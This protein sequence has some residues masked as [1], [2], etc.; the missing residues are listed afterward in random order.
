[1]KI[2]HT[3]DWHLGRSLHSHRRYEEFEAFLDWLISTIE[4]EKV[5]ALL[6]AGDIFDTGTPSNRAQSL[7]YK[8]L[9]KVSSTHCRHIVITA[10]NHDSPTFLNASK[11]LLKELNVH[12]VGAIT[13]NLE[14]EVIV[15]KSNNEPQAIICAVPYLRDKDIRTAEPGETIEDKNAK[16]IEGISNHYAEVYQIAQQKRVELNKPN[17]PIIAMGHLFTAGGK[18][19]DG[20]GV[21]ELYI[22]SLTHVH[23]EKLPQSI[24][25]FALG[26]LHVPQLVSQKEHIRYSGSPIPMGFGEATQEKK[27]IIVEFTN[28]APSIEEIT[29]PTFQKLVR[30]QGTVDQIQAKIAELKEAE[31]QAWLEIEYTGNDIVPNLLE[32]IDNA[33]AETTLKVILVKNK[34]V[35]NRVAMTLEDNETLDD[36][37]VEEV[38][39]R[40]LDAEGASDSD[41]VEL[42]AAYNEIVKDL[43]E[44]DS[45][46]L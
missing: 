18:I 4:Q 20:D 2:L 32:I 8:F 21:R 24:D 34:Q 27:V 39:K 1:M 23:V 22:G 19:I 14:D 45:N 25:Y 28:S 37:T 11:E 40:R 31:S 36:L 6:V 30:I 3:S 46:A 35:S 16:L 13:D 33:V 41:R 17:L 42:N 29:I 12:V 10:G 9:G 38:F 7:Y 15:L 44:E 43:Q 5:D 26:H